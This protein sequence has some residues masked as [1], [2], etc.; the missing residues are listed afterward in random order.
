MTPISKKYRGLTP[1]NFERLLSMLGADRAVAG[2]QYE[3]IRQSLVLFFTFRGATD[4]SEL[5]DETFNRV[6]GRIDNGVAITTQNVI[7][8]FYGVARN[9]WREVLA[10]PLNTET[11]DEALL[12]E[13]NVTPT[14]H[15]LLETEASEREYLQRLQCL[16]L[17]LQK[18]PAKD[19]KLLLA[20]YQGTGSAKIENRQELAAQFNISLKTLRNKTSKLRGDIAECVKKRLTSLP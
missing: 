13:K 5:A 10:R 3:Q 20:Y 4:P 11:L 17:C 15:E 19:R 7:S 6:A 12:S 1:E 18:L 14:P 16:E 2:E 8:Y 9:I